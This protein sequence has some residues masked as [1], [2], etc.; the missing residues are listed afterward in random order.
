MFRLIQLT[1]LHIAPLPALKLSQLWG[2][3][4]TGWLNWHKGRHRVHN[5]DILEQ[6][7][8]AVVAQKADHIACTGDT[9]NLSLPQEWIT[10]ADILKKLGNPEDVSFVPGNHDAYVEGALEGLLETV[11][12]YVLG[13][14]AQDIHFPYVRRRGKITLIGLS[15]AIPTPPFKAYG[16]LGSKQLQEL[17]KLLLELGQD[18][19]CCRVIMIH[20]PPLIGGTSPARE[21]KDSAAFEEVIKKAGA[22]LV[23]YGHN[24]RTSIAHIAGPQ[25]AVPVIGAP[26]ASASKADATHRAAYHLFKIE[27]KDNGH[28]ITLERHGLDE[29]GHDL[30]LETRQL[31]PERQ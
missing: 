4:L 9:T 29:T 22:E 16:Q 18:H 23:I 1:D 2:K 11:R 15:S 31:T 12:P 27:D 28:V 13:D 8:H 3:R 14:S 17:E 25:Q 10:S 19:S 20:H 30:L 7:I 26:S 21:L 24:H 6:L 5:R